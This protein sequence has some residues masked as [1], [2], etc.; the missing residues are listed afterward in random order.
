ML[1]GSVLVMSLAL[2][3]G[4]LA[5]N[6][7]LDRTAPR[8]VQIAAIPQILEQMEAEF[9]A[10]AK[11]EV[12]QAPTEDSRRI[13]T[14]ASGD[15][16][17]VTGRITVQNWYRVYI[18]GPGIGYV[19]GES[20]GVPSEEQETTE[21]AAAEVGTTGA[22]APKAT[23]TEEIQ[24]A[25]VAPVKPAFESP[26]EPAVARFDPPKDGFQD[27]ADC[28]HMMP[29]A[30]G[31]FVM[32]SAAG[33]VTERPLHPVKIAHEFALG[34]Y[35]VTV[36]QWN[37][38]V[39]AG[40][41][42]FE[43]DDVPAPARTAMRNI[44]WDDAQ[45]YVAWLAKTTGKPY[46]LPSEAEWEYAA[47]AGTGSE[48]WWGDVIDQ[49]KTTCKDCGGEWD[50]KVSGDIGRFAP[51][52][53]GLYDV[54]GGVSEWLADC[55]IKDYTR[56]PGDGSARD[57]DDCQQRV[58]RGGSWRNE[59]GYLRSAARLYYDANVNYTVHGLRVALTL[60]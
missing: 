5:H 59:A 42:S 35:E 44:S 58:L 31:E 27:C 25:V 18:K 53:F 47:R 57:Q 37:I 17:L 3:G 46:R 7:R 33:D 60:E 55:W 4:A 34:R 41:C 23:T 49:E 2:A 30:A 6:P 13:A 43:P 52:P 50:R 8:D 28:P 14:L 45:E 15:K 10:L 1:S 54:S 51:N 19:R 26:A 24:T 32:G 21:T 11:V 39:E 40:G 9:V 22:D 56:S 36:A 16:V 38:C 12:W 20:V 48:Y 29:I